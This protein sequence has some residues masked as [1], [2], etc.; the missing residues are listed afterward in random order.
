MLC[1][2]L[3]LESYDTG[4]DRVARRVAAQMLPQIAET[5]DAE[6]VVIGDPHR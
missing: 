4:A 1:A 3:A 2:G 5:I 6:P